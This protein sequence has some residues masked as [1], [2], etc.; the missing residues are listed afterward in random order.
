MKPCKHASY[1]QRRMRD[2]DRANGCSEFDLRHCSPRISRNESSAAAPT[3]APYCIRCGADVK[4]T[5]WRFVRNFSPRCAACGC[6]EI[7]YPK[8]SS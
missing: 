3:D 6:S 5:I 1:C 7:A 8:K 4:P 2:G